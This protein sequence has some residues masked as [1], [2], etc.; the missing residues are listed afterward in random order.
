MKISAVA[1]CFALAGCATFPGLNMKSQNISYVAQEINPDEMEDVAIDM[2]EFLAMQLPAAKT[3]IELEQSKTVFHEML[4]D[5]LKDKGFAV[6]ETGQDQDA[7][8]VRY[9]VTSLD[10]GVLLRV[11]YRGHVVS[12]FYSRK[13]GQ[14]FAGGIAVREAEK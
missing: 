5:E 7:V 9:V 13:D 14:L 3:T 6:T 12:R 10:N 8:P 1:A 11:K 4:H 2:A